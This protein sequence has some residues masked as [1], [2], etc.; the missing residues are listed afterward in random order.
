MKLLCI[1]STYYA[2]P[3][4]MAAIEEFI[5]FINENPKQFIQ[6]TEYGEEHCVAPYFIAEDTSVVYLNFSEVNR[7]FE[8]EAE[9]MP[10][11]EYEKRLRQVVKS[12]CLDCESFDEDGD[13]L[14][15]HME[16]LRL[17]GYCWGYRKKDNE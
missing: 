6:M 4:G 16:K 5:Q 17:D 7:I 13:D 15:G 12:K 1:D 2:F 10:R 9:V 8:I 14:T 3:E 11:A